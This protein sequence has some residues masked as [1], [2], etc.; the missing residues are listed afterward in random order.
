MDTLSLNVPG[1]GPWPVLVVEP[2]LADAAF[3][4]AALTPVPFRITVA[5]HFQ[6]AKTLIE[7]RP[8]MVLISEIRLGEFNGLQ[9]VMRAR[10]AR[11][12]IAALVT[13]DVPD[14]VLQREAERLGATF[15]VKPTTPGEFLAAVC[16]T[17]F[18]RQ[19]DLTPILVRPPFERR[20]QERRLS[21]A[22]VALE[23]RVSERRITLPTTSS[24]VL[25]AG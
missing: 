9:L 14:S 13:T 2:S 4:G 22:P 21:A 16:R 15:V 5:N 11:L 19:A 23:R 6:E 7:S 24:R 1:S 20:T 10:A 3:I 12:S 8:P 17:A 25:Y 18:R